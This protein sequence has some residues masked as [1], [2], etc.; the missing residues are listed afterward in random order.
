MLVERGIESNDAK[1]AKS[2]GLDAG[3][4]ESLQ[5]WCGARGGAG[6]RGKRREWVW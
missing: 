4:D 5:A 6:L 2:G 3:I 1:R